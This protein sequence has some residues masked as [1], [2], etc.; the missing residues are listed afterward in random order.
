MKLVGLDFW[1]KHNDEKLFQRRICRCIRDG[2]RNTL[3][4]LLCLHIFPFFCF[5]SF[6]FC[7]S[8]SL[9]W[10]RWWFGFVGGAT[11]VD[12]Y[13][14]SLLERRRALPDFQYI[15][16]NGQIIIYSGGCFMEYCIRLKINRFNNL[17][18]LRLVKC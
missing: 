11:N 1:T 9:C 5:V 17:D 10:K 8:R 16:F 2:E 7:I 13:I 12:N 4:L 6:C 15:F 18:F 14:S 3:R